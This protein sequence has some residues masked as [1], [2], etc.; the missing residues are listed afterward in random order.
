MPPPGQHIAV[1]D[2]EPQ[3]VVVVTAL[4]FETRAVLRHLGDDWCEE[5]LRSGTVCYRGAFEG[6]DVVVVEAGAGNLRAATTAL[7]AITHYEPDLALFVGIAGGVK[8]VGLAD[9]VIASKVYNYEFG[10]DTP[11]GFLARPEL[12][13]VAHELEQRARAMTKRNE[14]RNRLNNDIDYA[15]R[16]NLF[17]GP[18]AAGEKVVAGSGTRTAELIKKHFNDTLAVEMEGSGF[19]QA[20]HINR[21]VATV[22][23]GMSDLL[24]NKAKTDG[25]GLQAKAADAAS[26]VAFEML[27]KLN[28]RPPLPP[29]PALRAGL[30]ATAKVALPAAPAAPPKP[31]FLETRFT[32]N[33]ASFFDR[34]EVLARVGVPNVDEIQFRFQELPHA[35]VRIIPTIPRTNPIPNA[36]LLERAP[37]APLLKHKQFG[38][39]TSR[40]GHGAMAYDPGPPSHGG[41]APLSWGTQLFPNGELWLASNTIII[42]ERG[43]RPDWVPLP[44]IPALLTEQIFYEKTHAAVAFA[45]EQLGLKLPCNIE[46]GIIDLKGV[47]LALYRD[48]LRGPIPTDKVIL[49]RTISTGTRKEIDAALL[50][51]FSA[52]YDATGYARPVSLFD[53]P[54]NPPHDQPLVRV[55]SR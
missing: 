14:W 26:A 1:T 8:D 5:I 30:A 16:P 52:L 53:F 39:L 45:E 29:E 35:Y 36:V 34:D 48:D 54:P 27:S 51:F 50:D 13:Q 24:D 21:V 23:R 37:P 10:R 2:A 7:E 28:A 6:W 20:A 31:A 38:A 49:R 55:E 15:T 41:P 11:D 25:Q 42:R 3:R 19:F 12:N 40:N 46:L 4:D 44:F 47:T 9:V 33:A 32:L 43:H 22:I 18:I 17:V